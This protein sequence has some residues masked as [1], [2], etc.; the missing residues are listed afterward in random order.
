MEGLDIVAF[1]ALPSAYRAVAHWATLNRHRLLLVV[2]PP[3][4]DGERAGPGG[5]LAALLPPEQDVLVTRRLRT[6][7][8]PVIAALKPDVIVA[9]S[10][11]HRI[12]AEV[13]RIPRFGAV[14]LHPL[15]PCGHESNPDR[16]IDGG[17]LVAATVRLISPEHD[18]G[19]ILALRERRIPETGSPAFA[20]AAWAQVMTAALDDAVTRAAAGD[21]GEPPTGAWAAPLTDIEHWLSWPE[22]AARPRA[23]AAD[24]I[25]PPLPTRHE[26]ARTESPVTHAGRDMVP[27]LPPRAMSEPDAGPLA[28]PI[29]DGYAGLAASR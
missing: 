21:P 10:F 13:S 26:E 4:A 23:A 20:R 19:P 14:N 17:P 1:C 15:P 18:A 3:A 25:A 12:P 9:A 24:E 6:T 8:A 28:I 22:P 11:P 29:P 2:A 27:A 5:D 7:A 16:S